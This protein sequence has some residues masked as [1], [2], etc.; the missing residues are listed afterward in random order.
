MLLEVVENDGVGLPLLV[1]FVGVLF[2]IIS[3]G[4]LLIERC[5]CE[6][7]GA[8]LHF[9]VT[10]LA[11][12]EGKTDAG[13]ADLAIRK[14]GCEVTNEWFV[15]MGLK[16]RALVDNVNFSE[17]LTCRLVTVE[18]LNEVASILDALS[19]LDVDLEVVVTLSACL[20]ECQTAH[21]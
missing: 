4:P 16:C 20:C 21:E 7:E 9:D 15:Q 1:I 11:W 6:L 8:V 2:Q 14:D 17:E 3:I 18:D 12:Y 13:R 5:A 19:Y 10:F